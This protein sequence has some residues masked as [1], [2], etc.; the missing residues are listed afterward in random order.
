M[1]KTLHTGELTN[2]VNV[3]RLMGARFFSDGEGS[4]KPIREERISPVLLDW[5]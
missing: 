4:Y 5:N 3:L 2:Y 1:V